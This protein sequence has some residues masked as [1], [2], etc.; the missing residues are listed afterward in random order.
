MRLFVSGTGTGVGK[1]HVVRAMT[2]ALRAAGEAVVA[3]KPIETGCDPDPVDALALAEACG[4]PDVAHDP[5][6][7]RAR[8]ALAPFAVELLGEPAIDTGAVLDAIC[9]YLAEPQHVLVEG[10]GG[11]L[12]PLDSSRT[13]AELAL[14]LGLPVVLVSID[15]LGTLSHTLS[16]VE[17]AQRRG[18]DVG[19]VVVRQPR[20]TDR[21]IANNVDI[22]RRRLD[23]PVHRFPHVETLDELALAG[24]ALINRMRRDP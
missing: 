12:V 13:M 6:F 3:L 16:A 20:E 18:L 8:P 23:V 9:A 10:A 1:T 11:I 24:R 21:S 17:C 4:R 5:G 7:Y 15:A 22:L 2:I 14:E 19:A